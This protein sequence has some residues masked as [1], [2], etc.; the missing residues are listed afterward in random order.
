MGCTCMRAPPQPTSRGVARQNR[1][2]GGRAVGR[3][4]SVG[5]THL[6]ACRHCWTCVR[7]PALLV[8]VRI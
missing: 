1:G 5:R 3:R 8:G 7:L 6:I 2:C 4:G